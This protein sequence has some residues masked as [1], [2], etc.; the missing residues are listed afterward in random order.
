MFGL[1]DILK[2]ILFFT[3]YF[4]NG[5]YPKPLSPEEEAYYLEKMQNRI[6]N[7]IV[8]H[9]SVSDKRLRELMNRTDILVNDIGSILDG[10]EAVKCGLIDEIGGVKDALAYLKSRIGKDNEEF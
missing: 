6:I 10:Y 9:S 3:G 7:F 1:F 2:K 5:S 4:S 8:K